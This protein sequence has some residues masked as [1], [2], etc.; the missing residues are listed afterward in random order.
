MPISDS[1]AEPRL[2]TDIIIWHKAPLRSRRKIFSNRFLSSVI[3]NLIWCEKAKYFPFAFPISF[4][5][6]KCQMQMAC[7]LFLHNPRGWSIM[8]LWWR[9]IYLCHIPEQYFLSLSE[10][11]SFLKN[12]LSLR[13]CSQSESWSYFSYLT[14]K[15]LF[16]FQGILQT[17]SSSRKVLFLS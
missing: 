17:N 8:L 9:N 10:F 3:C 12:F 13:G 14:R 7:L 4:V 6:F 15:N 1:L 16:V 5:W 11:I 2:G